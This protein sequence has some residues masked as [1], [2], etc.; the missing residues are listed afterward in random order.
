MRS[1][2]VLLALLLLSAACVADVVRLS[3]GDRIT[4]TVSGMDSATVQ[5]KTDYAGEVKIRVAKVVEISS[6][7]PLHIRTAEND[8]EVY[9]V[10]LTEDEVQLDTVAAGWVSV[11]TASVREL[12]S[13]T[14]YVQHEQ[15][16]HA[17]MFQLWSGSANAGFS[18]S[19]GNSGATTF[20]VGMK[21]DR[22][23]AKDKFD[24]FFNSLF[25]NNNSAGQTNAT[26]ANSIRSGLSYAVNLNPRLFTFA[27][28]NFETD[29][30]QNLDLRNVV[31]GGMGV[32]VIRGQHISWDVFSGSSLNQEFYSPPIQTVAT[33]STQVQ[34]APLTRRSG[35]A[36]VGEELT[37]A[38]TP[39]IL[40]SERLTA[41]PNLSMPGE[42]RIGLESSTTFKLNSWLGWQVAV[43]DTYLSNPPIGSVNND[44]LISTGLRFSLGQE[45]VFRPRSK[46]AELLR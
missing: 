38:P 43:N 39:G 42:Y 45:H 17:G 31:G 28:T 27:F 15:L 26:S 14:A 19:R 24:V 6:D 8:F 36:L 41:F 46:V 34:P 33:A 1:F 35:E 32:N 11:P 29:A 23:S 3:N 5:I 12:L 44:L 10:R 13:D 7:T 22:V 18:A 40:I 9:E 21:A 30:L 16:A 4:G 25:A 2:F 37:H 20:S